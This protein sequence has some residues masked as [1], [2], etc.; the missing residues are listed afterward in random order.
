MYFKSAAVS[1]ICICATACQHPFNFDGRRNVPLFDGLGDHHYAITTSSPLA[2]RYFDQGLIWTYAFNHDEAIRSFEEAG[3]LDP[4]CAMA[5]W[6][7]ALCH[8]P[9]INN[10]V[11][12]A[13]R[14]VAAWNALQKAM[15]LRDHCTS[16]E[17]QLI[18][19]LSKRYTTPPPENRQPLNQAYADA[20][21][22]VWKN[23][24]QD[25][26]IGTLYAE[27]LMD[28]HPWDLWT[29]DRQPKSHTEPILAVLEN[30]M[31]LDPNNPG[32]NHLYIHA[33][34]AS[35]DPQ[36]ADEAAHRLRTMVPGSGHLVH[37]P[38][39]IDVLT[40]RWA[41]AV[42]QNI[43][44]SKID[45]AYR[46]QSPNQ[47][48]YHLYMTHNSH[49]LSF[50]AMMEGR[51]T[52]A[53]SSARAVVSNVPEEALKDNAPFLDPIM[54][55]PYDVMKRFGQWDTILQE[56]APPSYL[57]ITTAMWR[58]HRGLAHAAKGQVAEAENEKQLFLNAVSD[59]PDDALMAIN[60]AHH[61]L[62]IA[63]HMLDGEILFRRGDI[64]QAVKS[65]KLAI[66]REDELM[67][68]EPPEWVQPVRHTLGA[69]LLSAGRHEE[70]ERAYREDLHK[71]PE[72]GWSLLGLSKCLSAR[73]LSE[74]EAVAARLKTAWARADR[75]ISSS[76]LCV[77]GKL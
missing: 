38:S 5:W 29:Q 57:P 17:R 69:V 58:F 36:R 32:V 68:M 6:G 34:E 46:K 12:P 8:G 70:A 73:Q 55:A 74:A 65:L 63:K 14:G 59:V 53:M 23:H 15:A 7:V 54:C 19:A 11:M 42:Q 71:W 22:T 2:Q 49:M 31:Q 18:E 60:S 61:V 77:P 30:V 4:Q 13:E 72:N 45:S 1:L 52:L 27:S 48:F 28:L 39:H 76:C 25:A 37:M 16:T 66:A 56:P 44:A 43:E 24:P 62:D 64:N 10:P 50:A 33:V 20:M 26:D 35:S 47:G 21:A 9:H 3:R 75:G 40:G 67:Y 41:L 51:S